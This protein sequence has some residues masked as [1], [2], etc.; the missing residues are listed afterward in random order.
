MEFVNGR[1][2][3][4]IEMLREIKADTVAIRAKT[5]TID[6]DLAAVKADIVDIEERVGANISIDTWGYATVT[7]G[8]FTRVLNSRWY[9]GKYLENVNPL[10]GDQ[11]DY[12]I[13]IVAG[14]YTISVIHAKSFLMGIL[15][16]LIDSAEKGSI[17]CYVDANSTEF[18]AQTT[19]YNVV[20]PI[21]GIKIVS[22]KVDGKNPAAANYYINVSA[23]FLDKT[24]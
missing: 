1:P 10:D 24:A 22:F 12:R 4:E 18:M 11:V 21:T 7:Q 17:D 20:V 9:Q 19:I 3:T 6:V 23:L 2:G 13:F 14:T 16:V 15:K 8:I 5:D